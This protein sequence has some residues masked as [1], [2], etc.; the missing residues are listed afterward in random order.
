[1]VAIPQGLEDWSATYKP[2]FWFLWLKFVKDSNK[3]FRS[4]MRYQ[5]IKNIYT[6]SSLYYKYYV[7]CIYYIISTVCRLLNVL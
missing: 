3:E 4:T 5:P 7:I 2:T 1:M 6:I